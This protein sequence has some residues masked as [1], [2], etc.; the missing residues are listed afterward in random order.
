M[1]N[2]NRVDFKFT[3]NKKVLVEELIEGELKGIVGGVS[4]SLSGSDISETPFIYEQS[5]LDESKGK[6]RTVKTKTKKVLGETIEQTQEVLNY[7]DGILT[8]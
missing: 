3:S 4:F 1:A 6:K 7:V 8:S 5:I 2:I